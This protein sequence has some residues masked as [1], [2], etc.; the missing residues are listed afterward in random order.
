MA[1]FGF[2]AGAFKTLEPGTYQ[3]DLA[4]GFAEARFASDME[5][6]AFEVCYG[7]MTTRG[8]I[9]FDPTFGSLLPV[10]IGQYAS[11]EV[12]ELQAFVAGEIAHVEAMI[13]ER[14]ASAVLPAAQRLE[15][16][17]AVEV[18]VRPAEQQVDV[19]LTI[20]NGLG[21]SVGFSVSQA[22]DS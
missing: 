17:D 16:L 5:K 4:R 8:S 14:Q 15:A 7:L 2:S 11:N 6:L 3:I 9:P 13:K 20:T 21:E 1:T 10:A 22:V 19:L 12:A 18:R